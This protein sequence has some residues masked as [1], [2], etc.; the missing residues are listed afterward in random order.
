MHC[1][2]GD[3]RDKVYRKKLKAMP[4][5]QQFRLFRCEVIAAM[6]PVGDDDLG[7]SERDSSGRTGFMTRVS[8]ERV[9]DPGWETRNTSAGLARTR[10]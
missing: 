3:V 10:R 7:D 5:G 4:W 1:T 9:V 6:L 2:I 8:A